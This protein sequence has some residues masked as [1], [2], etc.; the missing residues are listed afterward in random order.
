MAN[1]RSFGDRMLKTFFNPASLHNSSSRRRGGGGGCLLL[2]GIKKAFSRITGCSSC[3]SPPPPPPPASHRSP[4]SSPLLMVPPGVAFVDHK[5]TGKHDDSSSSSNEDYFHFFSVSEQSQIR[6][7]KNLTIP[8]QRDLLTP[9]AA[10]CVGSSHGGWL[11]FAHPRNSYPYL[12]NPLIDSPHFPYIPLP[13]IETL[14]HVRGVRLL[15]SDHLSPSPSLITRFQMLYDSSEIYLS[16]RKVCLYYMHRLAMSSA[17][18]FPCYSFSSSKSKPKL[19]EDCT[20]MALHGMGLNDIAFCKPGDDRWTVL[21]GS[22][23]YYCDIMYF[24]KDQRF[25]ALKPDDDSIEAWDLRDPSC[26]K[27]QVFDSPSICPGKLEDKLQE[28]YHFIQNNYLV[29]S[30]GDL[31]LLYRFIANIITNSDDLSE[32]QLNRMD[33]AYWTLGFEVR[34]FDFD[35]NKWEL[36]ECLGDRALFVGSN[37]SFSLSTCDHPELMENSI[38]FTDD[39]FDQFNDKYGYHDNGVFCLGENNIKPYYPSSVKMIDP[40]P[41]W[42]AP[43]TM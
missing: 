9:D 14:P 35:H 32:E 10:R 43:F 31:L 34:K 20:I 27:N 3:S 23:P 8:W 24:S 29:E 7:P 2:G 28:S 5:N 17:P 13:S 18:S 16:S 41:I 21:D 30:S 6:V 37:Q 25:Y 36:V 19:D 40:H 12:Y 11:A 42:V 26:P 1:W 33:E 15:K 39:N 4:S 38:Y 22:L